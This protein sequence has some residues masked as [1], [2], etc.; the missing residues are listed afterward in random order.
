M[1]DS[2]S[3]QKSP[4]P[5]RECFHENCDSEFRNVEI[6]SDNSLASA[7]VISGT[8]SVPAAINP[9]RTNITGHSS[10]VCNKLTMQSDATDEDSILSHLQNRRKKMNA[11]FFSDN[12]A[13]PKLEIRKY[14]RHHPG[15]GNILDNPRE[16][17]KQERTEK[18]ITNRLSVRDIRNMFENLS[19]GE[20]SQ[21]QRIKQ[22]RTIFSTLKEN[23]YHSLTNMNCSKI[24]T[25][26][27]YIRNIAEKYGIH[28]F[29]TEGI[30]YRSKDSFDVAKDYSFQQ[31]N[32]DNNHGNK[33][34]D[35]S[36]KEI[37]IRS[38]SCLSKI[39]EINDMK[40]LEKSELTESNKE[41][42]HLKTIYDPTVLN[43]RDI[44]SYASVIGA[45]QVHAKVKE[46]VGYFDKIFKSEMKDCSSKR[47]VH[48]PSKK[49]IQ[50]GCDTS[51]SE[52]VH[53]EIPTTLHYPKSESNENVSN[54]N[55]G[56]IDYI[57]DDDTSNFKVNDPMKKCNLV[58]ESVQNS[59]DN[60]S[61]TLTGEM[62][63]KH[64]KLLS[65]ST[66]SKGVDDT[67]DN[68]DIQC[69]IHENSNGSFPSGTLFYNDVREN[70][71]LDQVDRQIQS[72]VPCER[73]AIR[74]N[75]IES[76]DN[77]DILCKHESNNST[78][79]IDK[80]SLSSLEIEEMK[81]NLLE[82]YEKLTTIKKSFLT[83]DDDKENVTEQ[84]QTQM[85]ESEDCSNFQNDHEHNNLN[86]SQKT[87]NQQLILFRELLNN[88][89]NP[90]IRAGLIS[91]SENEK[92]IACQPSN[93]KNNEFLS[94]LEKNIGLVDFS[95]VTGSCS[96]ETN[97]N[98]QQNHSNQKLCEIS[99]RE[100][101]SN[102]AS[103]QNQQLN[104]TVDEI[105]ENLDYSTN[106]NVK[107]KAKMVN[108]ISLKSKSNIESSE[109]ESSTN[110]KERISKNASEVTDESTNI[111]S[112]NG[113]STIKNYF[114]PNM[115]TFMSEKYVVGVNEPSENILR[116]KSLDTN[117]KNTNENNRKIGLSEPEMQ[118]TEEKSEKCHLET[119]GK[120]YRN[121]DQSVEPII[122]LDNGDV[123]IFET[124]L[125]LCAEECEADKELGFNDENII[126]GQR[127]KMKQDFV[128]ESVDELTDAFV[129]DKLSKW[130]S[131]K[132]FKSDITSEEFKMSIY[133]NFIDNCNFSNQDMSISI[134]DDEESEQEE[135][136][137]G[138]LDNSDSS[139]DADEEEIFTF[140]RDFPKYSKQSRER[141]LLRKTPMEF[142]HVPLEDEKSTVFEGIKEECEFHETDKMISKYEVNYSD[143]LC[144][145][146]ICNEQYQKRFP[147]NVIDQDASIGK[148]N[149]NITKRSKTTRTPQQNKPS[150]HGAGYN[151]RITSK[152][153]FL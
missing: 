63:S 102:V 28:N 14:D 80:N 69:Q 71:N 74:R 124:R 150:E 40:F 51:F 141:Q 96:N 3:G 35:N 25:S 151:F 66:S 83:Y 106:K 135:G 127:N 61:N 75:C 36:I 89:I 107:T 85:L 148:V 56:S 130:K 7:K 125:S 55:N 94:C 91:L 109:K 38:D 60:L 26:D 147:S 13:L 134:T 82:K 17:D 146:N 48:L 133:N 5:L 105:F 98:S 50:F 138:D 67:Q 152:V 143:I 113:I 31:L 68:P 99:V 8:A 72:I 46:K 70:Q 100:V 39:P 15:G 120:L 58:S 119:S 6:T 103:D 90:K 1:M 44:L 121:I 45:P 53:S 9:S 116:A 37:S 19:I 77:I 32:C 108:Y 87:T 52:F 27:C 88:S 30:N 84:K 54:T 142:I 128:H 12:L 29:S 18:E 78:T 122:K 23:Q 112:T 24:E 144:Y 42:E 111:E 132:E 131:L 101:A 136:T 47:Y 92:E 59:V 11:N 21:I 79:S 95:G 115:N 34:D 49:Y 129:M 149:Y 81:E 104:A 140:G 4:R 43:N 41:P 57:V 76:N 145:I 117:E 33:A 2:T 20:I 114:N 126:L 86:F 73:L 62:S 153:T 137:S 16:G 65:M 22:S 118:M 139:D 97:K 93:H 123:S 110:E 10:F 64:R